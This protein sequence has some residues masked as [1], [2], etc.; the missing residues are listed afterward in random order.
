MAQDEGSET[1]DLVRALWDELAEFF[2]EY[3]ETLATDYLV[4]LIEYSSQTICWDFSGP[5]PDLPS[6]L[7]YYCLTVTDR[8]RVI[9]LLQEPKDAI[10]WFDY[11]ERFRQGPENDEAFT[12]NISSRWHEEL[13]AAELVA[14]IFLTLVQFCHEIYVFIHNQKQFMPKEHGRAIREFLKTVVSEFSRLLRAG[15]DPDESTR[16]GYLRI[17]DAL[18]Y[19]DVRASQLNEM[20][21]CCIEAMFNN[22]A[23]SIKSTTKNVPVLLGHPCSNLDCDA[24]K[25]IWE[26]LSEEIKKLKFFDYPVDIQVL[27]YSGF[28]SEHRAAIRFSYAHALIRALEVISCLPCH[29]LVKQPLEISLGG[30]GDNDIMELLSRPR[31]TNPFAVILFS[32]EYVRKYATTAKEDFV[33]DDSDLDKAVKEFENSVSEI[34]TGF[35][36]LLV[37]NPLYARLCGSADHFDKLVQGPDALIKK[38]CVF[39]LYLN[40]SCVPPEILK[41]YSS[42]ISSALK[43]IYAILSIIDAAAEEQ[44]DM[45]KLIEQLVAEI[46]DATL[47]IGQE[48]AEAISD[49]VGRIVDVVEDIQNQCSQ[50]PDTLPDEVNQLKTVLLKLRPI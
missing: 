4:P 24:P 39:N 23:K 22:P 9:N 20:K 10:C 28:P 11:V 25:E 2:R 38:F 12:I 29:D 18:S 44:P 48:P 50:M 31:V 7:Q 33:Q 15:N 45:Q 5:T 35:A 27:D 34:W 47:S 8:M 36:N 43:Q 14:I 19:F 3:G 16:Q 1:F 30:I 42:L 13:K 49:L 37:S 46:N 21:S 17:Y 6:Y 32:T 26:K 41:N 40:Y